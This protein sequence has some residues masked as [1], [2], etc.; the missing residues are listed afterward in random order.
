M[1]DTDNCVTRHRPAYRQRCYGKRL[2][3][4]PSDGGHLALVR[5]HGLRQPHIA[6]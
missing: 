3:A 1:R 5:P 6:T 2:R 4:S